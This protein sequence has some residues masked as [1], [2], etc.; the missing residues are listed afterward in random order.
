M[1]QTLVAVENEEQEEGREDV[2]EAMNSKVVIIASLSK[3]FVN[4]E[5][6]N[7]RGK[8]R[9]KEKEEVNM[10]RAKSETANPLLV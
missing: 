8:E 2:I 7:D 6:M 10:H 3:Q 9:C 1:D 5:L 4:V